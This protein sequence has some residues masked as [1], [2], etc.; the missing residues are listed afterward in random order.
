MGK[1]ASGASGMPQGSL[2]GHTSFVGS[3]A[4][5]SEQV[6]TESDFDMQSAAAGEQRPILDKGARP[7][8]RVV[9]PE[10]DREGK[11]VFKNVGAL[12]KNTS[13]AGRDFYTMKIGKLRLLVFPNSRQ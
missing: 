3:S 10:V 6:F 7:D 13:K 1:D 12:W 8:F 4:A 9:Q 11:V 2:K 5:N